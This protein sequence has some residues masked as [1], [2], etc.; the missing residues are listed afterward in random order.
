VSLGFLIVNTKLLCCGSAVV[1]SADSQAT[2]LNP[3]KTCPFVASMKGMVPA[4]PWHLAW[5][6]V[7]RKPSWEPG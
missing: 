7:A 6:V 1:R 5:K 3:P 2:A 4:L